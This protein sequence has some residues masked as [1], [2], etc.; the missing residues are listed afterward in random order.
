MKKE[1]VEMKKLCHLHLENSQGG[2]STLVCY[3]RNGSIVYNLYIGWTSAG[4]AE[5]LTNMQC[6]RPLPVEKENTDETT[7]EFINRIIATVHTGVRRV[8]HQ[9]DCNVTFKA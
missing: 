5:S 4:M 7:F 8:V 2:K 6:K 9:V 3:L 1:I